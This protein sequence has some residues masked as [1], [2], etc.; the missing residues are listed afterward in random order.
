[1]FPA[2]KLTDPMKLGTITDLQLA[3]GTRPDGTPV[4]SYHYAKTVKHCA[5]Y[6]SRL[7]D[8]EGAVRWLKKN[9]NHRTRDA[10]PAKK[11]LL[12]K[13][14]G[15]QVTRSLSRNRSNPPVRAFDKQ[16]EPLSTHA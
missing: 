9:G 15:D 10:W 5:G 7:F 2:Q 16:N 13:K 12:Q 4:A 3:L 6:S 1:M 11:N 8:V 14:S